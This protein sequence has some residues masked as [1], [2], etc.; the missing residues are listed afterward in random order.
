MMPVRIVL[1]CSDTDN[2]KPVDVATIRRWHLDRGWADIGYHVVLQPD[3]QRDKGRGLREKG[4]GVEGANEGS[5]H[6][7]LIGR[8][9]FTAQQF[10]AL[11]YFIDSMV[12]TY[13]IKPW[14]LYG[15]YQFPS[16]IKLGKTCPNMDMA[17][18]ITW[19]HLDLDEA[20]KPYLLLDQ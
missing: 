3:G 11:R 4:A 19:Y 17:R 12:T 10:H 20:I 7:C 6:V 8:D 5:T 15:H 14:E 16:A 18:I 2:G 9:R 13:S 1:H